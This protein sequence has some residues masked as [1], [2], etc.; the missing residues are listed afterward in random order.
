MSD[1]RPMGSVEAE[2]LKALWATGAFTT[3]AEIRDTLSYELAYT[4]VNTVLVRLWKKGLVARERVGRGFAYRAKLSEGELTATRMYA[5][6]RR[7][8]DRPA[9]LTRFVGSLSKRDL[10]ALRKLID[11][12][13]T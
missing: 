7:A 9:A 11:P 10:A 5:E 1:R 12:D 3:P 4:T 6:L 13:G 2:V 8:Q